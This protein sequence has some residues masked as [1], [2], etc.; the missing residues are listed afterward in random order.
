MVQMSGL[1]HIGKSA[2]MVVV[3]KFGLWP[4]VW[5]PQVIGRDIADILNTVTRYEEIFPA[6]IVIDE[7][8]GRK[9]ERGS[10]HPS[11]GSHFSEFPT[12]GSVRAIIVEQFVDI[13]KNR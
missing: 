12:T 10:S 6:G 1:G 5:H 3:V 9:A 8:P 13:P 4:F 11:P 7:E 2:I